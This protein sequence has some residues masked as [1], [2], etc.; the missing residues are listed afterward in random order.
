MCDYL[1]RRRSPPQ[2]LLAEVAF[3]VQAPIQLSQYS[4]PEPDIAVVRIDS[5]KYIDRHPAPIKS[6]Y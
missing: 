3:R 2:A 5:R 6:F 4:E 1:Q